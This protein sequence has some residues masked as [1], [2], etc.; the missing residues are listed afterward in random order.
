MIINID[1]I[2][3]YGYYD[4]YDKLPINLVS[5]VAGQ[6]VLPKR[7]GHTVQIIQKKMFKQVYLNKYYSGD[8]LL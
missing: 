3:P 7:H 8:S 4:R 5:M 6:V 2:K 1:D